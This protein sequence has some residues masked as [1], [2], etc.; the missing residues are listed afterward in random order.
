MPHYVIDPD[1]S[2]VWID[3]RSSVHPIHSSTDGVEGFLEVDL[4]PGGPADGE[5]P[6]AGKLSLAV[7]RLSSGNRMEDREL[8]KR[9]DARKFPT[10]EGRL[11]QIVRLGA[12]QYRVS[13]EI[14]LRGRSCEHE[15]EMTITAVDDRTIRLEGG[16]RFDIR[17]FGMEPPR[18]LMLK[19]EPVVEVRVDL[20]AVAES[21]DGRVGGTVREPGEE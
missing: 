19:V 12:G 9:L 20:F 3:A 5:R 18:I 10:I 11:G 1:R 14:S 8:Q 2:Q 15:D 21:G 6:P 7:E 4:G 16:S 13:G 17:D